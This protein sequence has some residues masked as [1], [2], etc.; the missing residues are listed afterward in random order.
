MELTYTLQ[1]LPEVAEKVLTGSSSKT[2]LF[3]G[4]MG[5]GKTTLIKEIAKNLGVE[6]A[7]NSPTFSIVNEHI[8][9]SEKLYHYDFY[10]LESLDEA[11]DI[12]IEDYLYSGHWNFVEWPE[13]VEA[14]LPGES[15]KIE[16]IKNENGS[17][18][19]NIMPVK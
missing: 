14:L 16:L 17:R 5:T 4:E 6:E 15:T 19:L 13:K 1:D 8:L 3:Y 10:R 12:G 2:L 9:N 18:T 11:L 7:V